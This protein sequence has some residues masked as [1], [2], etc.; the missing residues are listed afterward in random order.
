MPALPKS[1][2]PWLAPCGLLVLGAIAGFVAKRWLRLRLEAWARRTRWAGDDVIVAATRW[3]LPFLA[4]LAGAHFGAA[5]APLPAE[6]R[7]LLRSAIAALATISVTWMTADA[8][9]GLIKLYTGRAEWGTAIAPAAQQVAVIVIAGTGA[10]YFLAA[11]GV[12]PTPLLLVVGIAAVGGALAVRNILPDLLA[13]LSIAVGQQIH[14][15]DR[16]RLDAAEGVVTHVGWRA[17]TLRSERG[18]LTI[19]P[20]S[21][22]ASTVVIKIAGGSRID[23]TKRAALP[24]RLLMRLTLTE[25]TGLRAST[26]DEFVAQLEQVPLSV[27]YHHSLQF[28]A[29]HEYLTPTPVSEFAEWVSESLGYKDLGE[30]LSAVDPCASESLEAF[31]G[32]LVAT[33]R[34]YMQGLEDRRRAPAGQEFFFMKSR[35]FILSTGNEAHNLRELADILRSVPVDALYFHLFDSRLRLG[36]PTNDFSAWIIEN[37]AD[38]ELASRIGSLDPYTRTAEGLRNAVVALIEERI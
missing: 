26:L 6:T 19:V 21:R 10:L 17:T 18:E 4:I 20:N 36:A 29:E 22:L 7:S 27:V 28:A 32:R 16:I 13:G 30:L 35:I 14:R 37:Y 8:A 3:H 31:R 12:P 1:L 15:G 38:K 33:C 34:E 25:L 9:L 11:L 24:F 2:L 5:L 23:G